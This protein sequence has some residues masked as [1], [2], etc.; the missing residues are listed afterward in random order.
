MLCISWRGRG[1]KQR[2]QILLRVA[3][4]KRPF[5][6]APEMGSFSISPRKLVPGLA[7]VIK[8]KCPLFH[9][10]RNAEYLENALEF[11]PV[12][13]EALFIVL[14]RPWSFKIKSCVKESRTAVSETVTITSHATRPEG[15]FKRGLAPLRKFHPPPPLEQERKEH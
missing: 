9:S 8:I 13:L 6:C 12:K 1:G 11:C 7:M 2:P 15:I 5:V 14:E 10:A 3:I 4:K